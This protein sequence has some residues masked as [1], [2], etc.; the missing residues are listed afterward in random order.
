[1]VMHKN[2]PYIRCRDGIYYF[3]MLYNNHLA[4]KPLNYKVTKTEC[5]YSLTRAIIPDSYKL[6]QPL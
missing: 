1:M 5:L 4:H 3:V 6:T 2:V